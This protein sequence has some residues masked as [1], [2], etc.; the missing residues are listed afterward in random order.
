[1]KLPQIVQKVVTLSVVTLLLLGG[2]LRAQEPNPKD[3]GAAA[4]GLQLRIYLDKAASAQSKIPKFRVEMRNVGREDLLLNFGVVT[5]NGEQYPTA[6]SLIL[7]DAH[8]IF[9][10]IELKRSVPVSDGGNKTLYLPLPIGGTFSFLVDLDNY[11]AVNSKGFDYKLEAGTYW[12]AAHLDGF[13][14]TRPPFVLITAGPP[15]MAGQPSLPA[16]GM[17]TPQG[18]FGEPPRSNILRFE[19]PSR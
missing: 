10:L 17:V 8:R 2:L 16:S 18:A 11:W 15:M 7:V 12:L 4:N 1:M 3:W 9:Q 13:I 19:V 6:V 5:R 14:T